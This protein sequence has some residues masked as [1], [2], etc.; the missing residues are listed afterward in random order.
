[1]NDLMF[2]MLI[3][4]VQYLNHLHI[5]LLHGL[6]CHLHY[7]ILNIMN[8][9][10]TNQYLVVN[11]VQV[12][13][14]YTILYHN[15]YHIYCIMVILSFINLKMTHSNYSSITTSHIPINTN[16]INMLIPNYC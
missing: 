16:M 6:Y 1:M 11:Q 12:Y 4:Y 3:I 8:S 7:H 15:Y 2:M 10:N 5:H 9:V 14:Y 13:T